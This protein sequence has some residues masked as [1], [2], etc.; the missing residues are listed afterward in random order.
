MIFKYKGKCHSR[1]GHEGPEGGHSYSSTL[2]LTLALNGV[3]RQL[4]GP[5][6]LAQET[7]R[8]PLHRRLRGPKGR[9]RQVRKISCPP[10]FDPR[11][12][13]PVASR[14]IDYATRPTSGSIKYGEFLDRLRTG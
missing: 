12:V 9:S 3:G 4:Q 11:N 2:S 10:G 1:T 14:Y 5:A 8:Y 6:A 13:Q 7:D